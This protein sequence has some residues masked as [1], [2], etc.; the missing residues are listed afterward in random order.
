MI[1][2]CFYEF[3]VHTYIGRWSK[4]GQCDA[5]SLTHGQIIKEVVEPIC[6]LVGSKKPD[7]VTKSSD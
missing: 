6:P 2:K 7:P 1:E 4:G 3:G 5:S